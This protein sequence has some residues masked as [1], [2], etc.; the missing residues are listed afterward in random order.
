LVIDDAR[1]AIKLTR[2]VAITEVA[3]AGALREAQRML[4]VKSK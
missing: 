4:G 1:N 2:P 3:D